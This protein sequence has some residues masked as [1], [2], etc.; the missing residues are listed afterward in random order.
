LAKGRGIIPR[1]SVPEDWLVE[2]GSE[3]EVSSTKIFRGL[4][5]VVAFGVIG[6][7]AGQ[8]G[9]ARVDIKETMMRA[10]ICGWGRGQQ[11]SNLKLHSNEECSVTRHPETSD[12]ERMYKQ[13]SKSNLNQNEP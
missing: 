7:A 10:E 12:K 1:D 2:V 13:L 6:K 3:R 11:E 4:E 5:R 9:G 8:D